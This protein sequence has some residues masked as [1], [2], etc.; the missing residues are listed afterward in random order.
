M[1]VVGD[2]AVLTALVTDEVQKDGLNQSF[3]LRLAD[4]GASREQV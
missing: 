3:T 2:T 1:V 4:L